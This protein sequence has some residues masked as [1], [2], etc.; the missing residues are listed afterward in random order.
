[1]VDYYKD[2]APWL[3]RPPNCCELEAI[4]GTSWLPLL[5]RDSYKVWNSL[6][7]PTSFS[8]L[9]YELKVLLDDELAIK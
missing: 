7:Y 2:G 1:M 3:L 5:K 9:L 8:D 6:G 4:P